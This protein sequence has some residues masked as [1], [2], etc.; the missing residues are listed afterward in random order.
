MD[1]RPEAVVDTSAL[2]RRSGDLAPADLAEQLRQWAAASDAVV[3]RFGAPGDDA[4]PG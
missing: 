2:P 1:G 3:A 4:E